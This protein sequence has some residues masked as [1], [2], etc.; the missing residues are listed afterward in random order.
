[1][2]IIAGKKRG[3]K[4][5]TLSGENT[6]PTLDRVRESLF[7]ILGGTC[8]NLSVLDVFAGS[9]SLGLEAFSRGA[10]E[11][12]FIEKNKDAAC[13]VEKNIKKMN[14]PENLTLIQED[15][16]NYLKKQ[17]RK[18]DLIFLDP[19]YRNTILNTVLELLVTKCNSDA[20]LVIETDGTYPLIIPNGFVIE[21]A[22]QY[23]RV[24]IT[25]IRYK[26]N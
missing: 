9:G 19:P 22:R 10:D 12:V 26:E 11:V 3:L 20:R 16:L 13:V 18:F 23:G 1:M 4:L 2:R 6:R 15:A 8:T 25:I 7:S 21:T 5:E 14:A 24:C 17:D